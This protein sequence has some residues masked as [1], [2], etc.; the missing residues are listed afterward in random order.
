MKD[1]LFSHSILKTCPNFLEF[2]SL[3]PWTD[4]VD[5]TQTLNGLSRVLVRPRPLEVTDSNNVTSTGHEHLK[6]PFVLYGR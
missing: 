6:Q 2:G 5:H 4:R 3:S 1:I